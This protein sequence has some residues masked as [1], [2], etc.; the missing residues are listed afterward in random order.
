[1]AWVGGPHDMTTVTCHKRKE[2]SWTQAELYRNH[3]LNLL[4]FTWYDSYAPEKGQ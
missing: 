4:T 2:S 3:L 1:V